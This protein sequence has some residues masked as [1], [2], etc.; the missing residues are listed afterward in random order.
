MLIRKIDEYLLNRP[1]KE[2]KIHCFHP[3]SLHL[4]EDELYKHY[5]GQTNDQSI[6][7]R[8]RR[9]FDNGHSMHRR[10]QRYL[11]DMG[12]LLEPEVSVE[13]EE[14]EIVGQCDGIVELQG[15]Q[16]VLEIKSINQ[17]GF[18]CLYEPKPEHL[19]QLNIYMWSLGIPK[20]LLL[21]ECKNTQ[22]LCEFFVKQDEEIV[23]KTLAKIRAVQDRL[24]REGFG[25]GEAK[26]QE[27]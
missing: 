8:V 18:H 11:S 10:I 12:V 26:T 20:G 5:L 2:R 14:Y 6:S 22:N 17:T 4:S 16:G 15:V 23:N 19:V 25:V 1:R 27:N 9:I 13:N 21:Y 7:A 3:S 24:R